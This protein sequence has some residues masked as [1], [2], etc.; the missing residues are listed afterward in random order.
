[1]NRRLLISGLFLL[2]TTISSCGGGGSSSNPAASA[3]LPAP[4]PSP[5]PASP[6]T[7]LESTA[8]ISSY[9]TQQYAAQRSLFVS[10]EDVLSSNLAASGMYRSG[11]HYA[12]SQ[13]NYKSHVDIFLASALAFVQQTARTML[14]D[15]SAVVNMLQQHLSTD[16]TYSSTYY[17][18]VDWGL[19]G[20]ALTSFI[21]GVQADITQAYSLTL[22][23][24]QVL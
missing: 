3:P 5:A 16:A 2:S 13:A 6:P 1:M 14:I 22:T 24:V 20:S 18:S 23:Q 21:A 7:P 15:K 4:S 19:T 17:S 8:F 9:L 12:R 11:T 10:D